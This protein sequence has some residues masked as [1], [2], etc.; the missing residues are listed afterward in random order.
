ME[1]TRAAEATRRPEPKG[2]LSFKEQKELAELPA[3]IEGMEAEMARV[4]ETL[5]DPASYR[6][7]GVDVAALGRRLEEL[8]AAVEAGWARWNELDARSS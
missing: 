4:Q 3:R 2:R 1:A 5:A 7:A 6:T 8:G